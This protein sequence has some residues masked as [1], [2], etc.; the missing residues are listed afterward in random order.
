V[1]SFLTLGVVWVEHSAITHTLRAADVTLYRINLLVLLLVTFVPFPTKLIP[2]FIA[3]DGPERVVAV[4]YGLTMLGLSLALTLF[5]R[6]AARHTELVK[7]E[8]EAEAIRAAMKHSPSFVIYGVGLVVSLVLPTAGIALY[9]VS[10][11]VRGIPPH[12][13]RRLRLG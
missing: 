2:E 5:G 12:M 8:V 11:M 10:A 4:F 1:T 13:L 9:L 7:D 6:Y 3:T